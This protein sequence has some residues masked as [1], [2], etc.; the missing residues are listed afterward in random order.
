VLKGRAIGIVIFVYLFYLLIDVF[1]DIGFD[2]DA[3][4]ETEDSNCHQL[5]VSVMTCTRAPNADD[6][7]HNS[8]FRVLT[9]ARMIVD[10]GP[11]CPFDAVKLRT[12]GQNASATLLQS[13]GFPLGYRSV[14]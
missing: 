10:F 4:T 11:G 2:W 14:A 5:P 8:V 7:I 3:E 9:P 13:A 6:A 1:V 12:A